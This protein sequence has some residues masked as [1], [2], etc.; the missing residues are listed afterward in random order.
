VNSANVALQNIAKAQKEIDKLEVEV[1]ATT[2]ANTNTGTKD[3][4]RKP[5]QKNEGVNGSNKHDAEVDT[6]TELAQEKDAV[7]DVAV[8]LEKTKVD[9]GDVES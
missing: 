4:T 8:E 2:A 1:V 3:N 6:G 7:N 9:D 5:T